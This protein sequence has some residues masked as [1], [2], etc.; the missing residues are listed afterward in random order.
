M[1]TI[2]TTAATTAP[3]IGPTE[4]VGFLKGSGVVN[5]GSSWANG[6]P[7]EGPPAEGP[8]AEGPPVEGPPV[9]AKKKNFK[10]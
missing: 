9:E 8:P 1:I 3:T 2:T 7:V 5:D 4:I 6:F 10:W